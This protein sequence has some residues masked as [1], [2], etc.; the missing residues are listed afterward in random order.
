MSTDS[1]IRVTVSDLV[2]AKGGVLAGGNIHV[3]LVRYVV[4]N[5]PYGATD[6][7]CGVTDSNPPYLMPDRLEPFQR[8][9]LPARSVRPIWLSVDISPRT[10]A[11]GY[12]GTITVSSEK[13]SATLRTQIT[14]QGQTLPPPS[15][16]K[17][18]LDL[19]QNPWVIAWYY[20]SEEH[21]SELQS[22]SFI[23][24]A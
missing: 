15:D 6:V 2:D 17:F 14:V 16:W 8:F 19:W 23:S 13:G 3:Y 18:R 5:Y 22:H 9:D 1:Q 10:P 4:S 7:S 24:Y 11:G 12:R 20:R 21:T